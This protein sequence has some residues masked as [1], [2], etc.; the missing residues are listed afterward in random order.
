[1]SNETRVLLMAS[2]APGVAVCKHL[3][4]CGDQIIRLHVEDCDSYSEQIVRESGLDEDKIFRNK[5]QDIASELERLRAENFDFLLTVY[6]PRLIPENLFSK[7]NKG[8][9]N[10]HPSLLPINRG[11][12]P[13]VHSLIDGTPAGVTL[14]A[15]DETADT[16]PIWVQKKTFISPLDTAKTVYERQQKEIVSLFKQFWPKIKNGEI[17]PTPQ[18]ESLACTHK[19]SEVDL[20]DEIDLDNNYKAIDLINLLKARSF[21]NRGFAYFNDVGQRIY[22]NVRLSRTTSFPEDLEN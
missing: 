7:A 8:T 19:K 10:F 11:Y 4:E 9:V 13:H 16:G 18:D 2:H 3:S 6:W 1:M 14:H 20:F 21:G 15:I 17:T 5:E 12:Y 22:L